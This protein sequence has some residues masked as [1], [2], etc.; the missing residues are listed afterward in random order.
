MRA[1][2]E[3]QRVLLELAAVDA[4]RIGLQEQARSMP[5]QRRLRDL[6]TARAEHRAWV[7]GS[8]GAV[9]ELEAETARLES[10]VRLVN[11]RLARDEERSQRSSSAKE[12]AG[13][14]HEIASLRRRR[15]QLED[16]EL[17]LMERSEAARAELER[18]RSAQR[19]V[20]AQA[21]RLTSERDA[22]RAEL[23][24]RA[25]VNSAARAA[26]L[27]RIEPELLA[28]YERQRER[29]GVGAAELVGEIT[30]G[31]NV[32]IDPSEL[33]RILAADPDEV[34]L[35]PDSGAVLVRTERSA[36]P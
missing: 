30:S 12:L 11:E 8:T 24:A 16:A 20:E 1:T 4:E 10:D 23:Q 5:E 3:A 19:E 22:R 18:A 15:E 13:L 31:S 28:L 17:E 25:K 34:L 9:E 2:P 21:E 14:E 7:A 26:L 32:R 33:S 27:R 6:Q 35:C 29:Y 36:K